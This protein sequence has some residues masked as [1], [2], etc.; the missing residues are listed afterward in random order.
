M[1]ERREKVM[2]AS[3]W[4]LVLA[5][6]THDS[7]LLLFD[8]PKGSA[9]YRKQLNARTTDVR[10]YVAQP[11][12]GMCSHPRVRGEVCSLGGGGG[13]RTVNLLQAYAA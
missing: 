2:I 3:R 12:C 1:L 9:A 10:T 13:V 6:L 4:H 5:I 11:R 8:V 7:Y